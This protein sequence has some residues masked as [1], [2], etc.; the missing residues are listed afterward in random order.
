M[1]LEMV[2]LVP[3]MVSQR[4]SCYWPSYWYLVEMLLVAY[5]PV[6][7]YLEM[8]WQFVIG[9]WEPLDRYYAVHLAC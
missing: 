7:G 5:Q 4:G 6:I 8:R 3:L 1:V 9:Y 2:V